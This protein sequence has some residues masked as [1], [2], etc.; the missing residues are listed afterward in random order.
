MIENIIAYHCG[1]A[2]AGI[3]PSNIVA[4]YKDKLPD[5]HESIIR[6]N[7]QLNHKDIYIEALCECEK[8]VLIMVYRRKKLS[9]QL[10]RNEIS[11]FLSS[12]G[13]D[14]DS[15]LCEKILTLKERIANNE[16]F[17]HEI[18]TFLGYPLH[19][20][21][22]FINH[23]NDGCLLTADWKVYEDEDGARKIFERYNKC[24][25]ALLARLKDGKTL[26]QIFCAA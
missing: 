17:P 14:S 13:Y 15:R 7:L 23:R 2:L 22:G 16:S 24:R 5:V 3:K 21:Y 1:P 9:E 25:R 26:A 20:I 11:D 19:D 10:S 18:G 12:F 4:C 8:R 6:L